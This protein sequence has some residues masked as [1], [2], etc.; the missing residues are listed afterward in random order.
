MV[1]VKNR[2][3]RI[4]QGERIIGYEGDRGSNSVLFGV[5][6]GD[7]SEAFGKEA[8]AG[9]QD[10]TADGL[11]DNSADGVA[12]VSSDGL[13]NDLTYGS[14]SAVLKVVL[15]YDYNSSVSAVSSASAYSA[16]S[17]YASGTASENACVNASGNASVKTSVNALKTASGTASET[18]S[19]MSSANGSGNASGSVS[20]DI[21]GDVS[22][23]VLC[24]AD[25][26]SFEGTSDGISDCSSDSSSDSPDAP[27]FE[28][29]GASS[30]E[31]SE[32]SDG[33]SGSGG[34]SALSGDYSV[35]E[36]SADETDSGTV[37]GTD[38]GAVSNT[39]NS[40]LSNTAIG[41]LSASAVGMSAVTSE[42]ES[43]GKTAVPIVLIP[44][45]EEGGYV[46][47]EWRITAE[48]AAV[49]G[50][51]PVQLSLICGNS[52]MNSEIG[53]FYAGQ[54]LDTKEYEAGSAE[55]S[56]IEALLAEI[57][58]VSAEAVR[59]GVSAGESAGEAK[60]SAEGALESYRSAL[61][62]SS[63][64]QGYAER[65]ELSAKSAKESMD[66]VSAHLENAGS[67][68]DR[69]ELAAG[70]SEGYA[71]RAEAVLTGVSG[72]AETVRSDMQSAKESAQSAGEHSEGARKALD[73]CA[74]LAENARLSADLSEAKANLS[75]AHALNSQYYAQKSEKGYDEL[76]TYV[77]E[78][79][80][81]ADNAKVSADGAGVSAG[82]AK[83][84]ADSAKEC[85]ENAKVSEGNAELSAQEAMRSAQSAVE[86]Y[87]NAQAVCGNIGLSEDNAKLSESNAKV[88]ENNA[89]VSEENAKQS[90]ANAGVSEANARRYAEEAKAYA[91]G[92]SSGG[93]SGGT[94]D[95]DGYVRFDDIAS[96]EKAG[97]VKAKS[98]GSLESG[99]TVDESGYLQ[100]IEPSAE[101]I[102]S[103]VPFPFALPL[104][105]IDNAVKSAVHLEMSDGYRPE[106]FAVGD[107]FAGDRANLPA[108]YSAVKGYI[109]GRTV[110][111][112]TSETSFK[113]TDYE[114]E[115]GEYCSVG[116]DNI[117][118]ASWSD[119]VKIKC[120]GEVLG[121]TAT[122]EGLCSVN[123]DGEYVLQGQ[124][125]DNVTVK[126]VK[127]NDG[128]E[129]YGS[130]TTIRFT[131]MRRTV[132]EE[133]G[134]SEAAEELFEKT[135]KLEN[136]VGMLRSE[137][138][139]ELGGYVRFDDTASDEKSG[140]VKVKG[141][142]T[143]GCYTE[144]ISINSSGYLGIQAVPTSSVIS[145]AELPDL[146]EFPVLTG[147]VPFMVRNSTHAEMSDDYD[148]TAFRPPYFPDGYDPENLP[149]S[150]RAVKG[151]I[152]GEVS[153]AVSGAE[154][155]LSS[156]VSDAS[157][158]HGVTASQV[159]AY[160]KEEADALI[161][162]AKKLVPNFASSVS[163][164]EE[165][166][167]KSKVYVLPDGYVY[168]YMTKTAAVEPAELYDSAKVSLNMRHSGTP[169]TLINTNGYITTD[170]MPVD[171]SSDPSVLRIYTDTD[172]NTVGSGFPEFGKIA[173]YDS[174][175]ACIGSAYIAPAYSSVVQNEN[176]TDIQ[177][178]YA[179]TVDSGSKF[180]Y[181]DK[182]AFVRIELQP[183]GSTAVSS[184][185]GIILS[186]KNITAEGGEEVITG[187]QS[188]GHSF[189]PAD[190]EDR[191]I[192]L[193]TKS[194]DFRKRILALE[195]DKTLPPK[196]WISAVEGLSD[197]IRQ[198]QSGGA[199]A[200]QFVWFSDMHGASGFANTGGA[201]TSDQSNLG[202]LAQY[203]CD[204]FNIPV[205][206]V[207]G[208]IMSQTSHSEVSDVYEEYEK[209]RNI[210]RYV[211]VKKLFSAGGNHDGA[212]GA[213]SGGIYYLKNIGKRALFNE[214]YRRQAMDSG[215]IF[216]D[217]GTYFYADF[218]PWKVRFIMLDSNTDGDGSTDSDGNAVYNSMKCS[219]YGTVQ[220]K[221]LIDVLGS[222]PDGF[223]VIAMAHQP[224][225]TSADG[226]LAA[227]IFT[228][229]NARTVYSGTADLESTYWGSGTDSE[230]CTSEAECDFT[231]AKGEFAVFFHGHIHRDRIDDSSYSFPCISI[232]TA[233]A[234]VRD[235]NP[236]ERIPGT[237]SETA[238]DIVTIDILN[239]TIY[240]TRVGAGS[241]RQI[242]Y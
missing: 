114:Y 7:I 78:A 56:A 73:K 222:V 51:I 34:A 219:V 3:M 71:V 193:E 10:V 188:T 142:G 2:R 12:A 230:F 173:Y 35:Y 53:Y 64:A 129:F 95:L 19:G 216:G 62:C 31:R 212:W 144:P 47:W 28:E 82:N 24:G 75:A 139:E 21:S 202:K 184:D 81:S 125:A 200:F 153:G 137:I 190:C 111:E 110:A 77:S 242:G 61:L 16:V 181:Y 52:V 46:I 22:G 213:P 119:V 50:C 74:E 106:D 9:A 1:K 126:P 72:M 141:R 93:G 233:G 203:I 107:S 145:K 171:M 154:A 130:A 66:A 134:V 151:Y 59:A 241:D 210:L 207:S 45:G 168:G 109:D 164:L 85:A 79:S 5:W 170:Y 18:V 115:A 48:I 196:Y 11:A 138:G 105:Q 54:S 103:K 220:L 132:S 99:V 131:D 161:D 229:Y 186:I 83:E 236:V 228:A 42:E 118:I 187:W 221:W 67:I 232:T 237:A 70:R 96:E 140:A 104:S 183:T 224:F 55:L 92:G 123:I 214:L 201:G 218:H 32:S 29:Y 169:G 150:Y 209:C 58:T 159:G 148:E 149:A 135:G 127:I 185:A 235:E 94:A 136:D 112:R 239:R 36:A 60:E 38:G 25:G 15:P 44:V 90:E 225:D 240:M 177:I 27:F 89:K 211:D 128:I 49:S 166:G 57:G 98:A 167:D 165:N 178:G 17:G 39:L 156:H 143:Y 152:D 20:C 65:A 116:A 37:S 160:T 175:K 179:G 227:G 120:A 86:A 198:H 231:S 205:A 101:A 13:T 155:S 197:T 97:V 14:V 191:I 226:S 41:T 208:D 113:W 199:D 133:I 162:G 6:S 102:E 122:S 172:I 100:L 217:G 176:E 40:T 33:A 91:G 80:R 192:A 69:A 43:D 195:E 121:F 4:T 124:A 147:A 215:R 8:G 146:E 68:A 182:I 108:S 23:A 206:A 189:I 26:G 117:S 180:D 30:A 204:N 223:T 63:S 194:T 157:N 88:S 163:E 158:P 76:R 84:Y 234:D 87:E 238:L 174:A